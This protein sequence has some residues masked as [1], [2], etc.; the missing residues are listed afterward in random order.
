MLLG[1]QLDNSV[2]SPTD[3]KCTLDYMYTK[4]QFRKTIKRLQEDESSIWYDKVEEQFAEFKE[5]KEIY[6]SI[7]SRLEPNQLT[8]EAVWRQKKE[9]IDLKGKPPEMV[10]FLDQWLKNIEN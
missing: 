10:K 4:N 3:E 7:Q 9:Q 8:A 5:V 6:E 1:P 2:D